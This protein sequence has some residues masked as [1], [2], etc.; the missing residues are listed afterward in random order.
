VTL[1]P[2]NVIAHVGPGFVGLS[3]E[4]SHLL[5]GFFRGDNT[6][7][8]AMLRLLGPS[9]LRVGGGT[10]D[11]HLWEPAGFDAG[12]PITP[13]DV[14]GFAALVH[15]AGWTALYGLP[16]KVSTPAA[17]AEE[18]SYVSAQLGSSLYGFEIGNEPDLHKIT[19]SAFKT[20]WESFAA[21][22]RAGGAG[23]QA[24]AALVR[25]R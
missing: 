20:Q 18:A 9:V 21:A 7:L 8:I 19:Y 24:S 6:A 22:I 2:G 17:A 12:A 23:S 1:T 4:K 13:T 5:D 3:Y 10:V 25:V 15:A 14:D 11:T 16:M